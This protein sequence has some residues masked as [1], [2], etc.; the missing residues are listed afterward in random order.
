LFRKGLFQQ[1]QH[2]LNLHGQESG[3]GIKP[4]IPKGVHNRNHIMREPSLTED[5]HTIDVR[6]L[7]CQRKL[8]LEQLAVGLWDYVL[9]VELGQDFVQVAL[10]G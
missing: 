8:G 9:A 4:Y 7:E 10:F 6:L 1:N 2:G 5:R 3:Q